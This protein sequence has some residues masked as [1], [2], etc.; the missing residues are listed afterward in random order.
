MNK[1]KPFVPSPLDAQAGA[2]EPLQCQ[3]FWEGEA[4]SA[5]SSVPVKEGEEKAQARILLLA[6]SPAATRGFSNRRCDQTRGCRSA[7]CSAAVARISG[8]RRGKEQP[9]H[10]QGCRP[11]ALLKL[12]GSWEVAPA[13]ESEAEGWLRLSPW[14]GAGAALPAHP[15]ALRPPG[16]SRVGQR[17]SAPR[18]GGRREALPPRASR[19]LAQ[20]GTSSVLYLPEPRMWAAG[21]GRPRS[22]Q[23]RNESRGRRLL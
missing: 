19:I 7:Y 16:G 12:P 4:Q 17:R 22:W 21:S 8:Q 6:V 2:A 14:A 9:V 13:A 18:P 23:P 10:T 5:A 3:H 15:S 1:P 20:V 11:G